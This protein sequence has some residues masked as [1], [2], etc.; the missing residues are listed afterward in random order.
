MSMET[1]GSYLLAG[2]GLGYLI[3]FHEA[4]HFFVARLSGVRVK[5]FSLGFGRTLWG[6]KIGETEY[7]LS[8]LPLGGYVRMVGENTG[9]EVSDDEIPVSF[10][11]KPLGI[12]AAIVAAGP[13]S[14]LI[15]AF[16][17]F[18][19]GL[20]MTGVPIRSTAVGGV[21]E[22]HPAAV[23]GIQKGDK[24][25]AIN[26][27]EVPSWGKMVEVIQKEGGKGLKLDILRNKEHVSI[28]LIPEMVKDKDIFGEDRT[29]YMVGISATNEMTT[30]AIGTLEAIPM[31]GVQVWEAGTL[32]VRSLNALVQSKVPLD[33][34]GGPVQITQIASDAA[35]NGAESFL[36]IIALISVNLAVLN[37]LPIPALDG[38]HLFFFLIEAIIRKPVS[39]KMREKAQQV[40]MAILLLLIALVTF[41]DFTRI[42]TGG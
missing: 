17:I 38:G 26:G 15:L 14:N 7:R 16:I 5:V 32:I 11:H 20:V 27:Q 36:F 22:N 28:T 2:L 31:A 9:D 1:I 3:F 18:Y 12:R 4:G 10:A 19:L 25:L 33:S 41:N 40:G 39:L 6:K 24:V 34:V 8:M 37:L 23:A 13:V 35:R 21:L 30:K 42:F 29:R